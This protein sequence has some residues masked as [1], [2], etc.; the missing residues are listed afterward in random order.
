MVYTLL[1]IGIAVVIGLIVVFGTNIR[2]LPGTP[3]YWLWANLKPHEEGFDLKEDKKKGAVNQFLV[4]TIAFIA[5]AI[6][7]VLFFMLT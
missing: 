3:A 1:G 5:F 2:P 6:I 4:L 7:A